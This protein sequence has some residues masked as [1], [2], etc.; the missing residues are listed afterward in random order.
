MKLGFYPKMAADGM[1]KNGK[2]YT[3]Y[4][5]TSIMMVAVYYILNF[6]GF[7]EVLYGIPGGHTATDLMVLGSYIMALFGLTFLFYTQAT[8]IKGRKKEFGLYSILGMNKKNISRIILW[9]TALTWAIALFGGL[10]TGIGLSKLAELTFSRMIT[11]S[12]SYTFTV[13][14]ISVKMT[15]VVFT[16]IFVLLYLNSVR[17]V[18]FASPIE[19]VRAD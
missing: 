15:I 4:F 10:L 6:L 12:T 13:S 9:E 19:L 8:L 14:Q 18:R 7:S 16:L 17:Q 2:L 11:A 3:P 1:H 5:I